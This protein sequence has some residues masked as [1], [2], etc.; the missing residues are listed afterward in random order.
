MSLFKITFVNHIHNLSKSKTAVPEI[1][2][3]QLGKDDNE[4]FRSIFDRL[5]DFPPNVP[6]QKA[7]EDAPEP[8]KAI[9]ALVS[10]PE[11]RE[12]L[13]KSYRV[14]CDGTRETSNERL[15]RLIGFKPDLFSNGVS[16]QT[17]FKEYF[18][19]Q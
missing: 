8:I 7:V 5:V 12:K 16:F 1:A 15:A 14:Y 6:L 9:V 10:T 18:L 19:Q 2:A 11:G 17:M 3:T 4:S 13:K